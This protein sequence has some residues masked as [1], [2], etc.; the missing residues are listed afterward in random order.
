MDRICPTMDLELTSMFKKTLEKQG[1]KFMLKTK[2]VGGSG[3]A[4]G[5]KVEIE[6]AQGG[7]KQVLES[8]YILVATGRRAYTG[9]L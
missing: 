6:P 8:D 4:N 2:V 9:G 3:S 7:A 1:L 5:C